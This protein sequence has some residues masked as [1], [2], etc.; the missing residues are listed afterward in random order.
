MVIGTGMHR[1]RDTIFDLQLAPGFTCGLDDEFHIISGSAFGPGGGFLWNGQALVNGMTISADEYEFETK[2][3][4]G[5]LS[6]VTTAIPEPGLLVLL[7]LG[8][9]IMPI[10]CRRGGRGD[11]HGDGNFRGDAAGAG[12]DGLDVAGTIYFGP[13]EGYTVTLADAVMNPYVLVCEDSPATSYLGARVWHVEQVDTP[14][15]ACPTDP[16]QDG[17]SQHI[18]E[19]YSCDVPVLP[20]LSSP[21]GG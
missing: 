14:S 12:I 15:S 4:G 3:S 19:T 13:G 8:I 5:N 1:V 16:F 9:G 18:Y 11:G 7:L 17:C 10:C 2:I 20:C 6:L 21:F